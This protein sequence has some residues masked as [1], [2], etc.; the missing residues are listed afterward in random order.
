M[1]IMTAF[2]GAGL[3]LCA[4]SS[5]ARPAPADAPIVFEYEDTVSTDM[6]AIMESPFYSELEEKYSKT[7]GRYL[8]RDMLIPLASGDSYRLILTCS[9]VDG[10]GGCRGI[11]LSVVDERKTPAVII[12]KV[13]LGEGYAPQIL[14]ASDETREDIM[15]R[16]I[17][18]GDNTEAR[19]YSI[20]PVT[21]RLTETMSITRAFPMTMKLDVTGTMLEGGIIEAEFKEPPG[22]ERIDLSGALNSLIED[23][24]YQPDGNPIP[25]LQNLKLARNGWEEAGICSDGGEPRVVAGMSLV[26]LSGKPVVE[27]TAVLKKDERGGWIIVERRFAPSLPYDTE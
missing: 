18:A 1:R 24:L 6:S 9:A 7:L 5:A 4:V 27:V 3:A 23:E 22:K 25:A 8:I 15:F 2:F 12:Q 17:R 11:T 21:G 16:A 10:T 13:R 14:T 20:N 26:T 19:V